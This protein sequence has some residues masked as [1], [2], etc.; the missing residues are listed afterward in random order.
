MFGFLKKKPLL[1]D[2]RF[3]FQIDTYKW[4]L[5]NFDSNYFYGKCPLILPT[6][7]FFPEIAQG[8]K[9][10]VN[11][12]F[13][14]VK[15]YAGMDSWECN[16]LAQD[17]DFEDLISKE[18]FLGEAGSSPLGTFSID[19]GKPLITYNPELRKKPDNL[20]ATFAHELAHL[21]I[22]GCEVE[23]PDGWENEELVTDLAAIFMGFGLFIANSSFQHGHFSNGQDTGWKSQKSGYLAEHEASFALAIFLK[24]KNIEFKDVSRYMDANVKTYVKMA[25]LELDQSESFLELKNKT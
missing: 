21:L 16:L 7:E 13:E 20:I 25:L 5:Q 11:D 18:L 15:D 2:D 1:S 14:Q 23:P 12:L 6:E 4:L 8:E 19:E 9:I 24:L 17:D 10:K 22:A 3:F